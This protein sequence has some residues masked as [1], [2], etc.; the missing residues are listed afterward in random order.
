MFDTCE[1]FRCNFLTYRGETIHSD[2]GHW[3]HE[4]C[5][6]CSSRVC[7]EHCR[8]RD[9]ADCGAARPDFKCERCDN[10]E[11]C[12]ECSHCEARYHHGTA[13]VESTCTRCD[14]CE[15]C[16]DCSH[17]TRCGPVESTCE[18]CDL[19]VGTS[20][21]CCQCFYCRNCDSRSEYGCDRCGRCSDCECDCEPDDDD[22]DGSYSRSGAP[23]RFRS[24]SAP[25]FHTSTKAKLVRNRSRRYAALEIEVSSAESGSELND[26]ADNWDAQIVRDGSLPSGGFEINTAPANGDLLLDQIDD[27]SD[28]LSA[29]SATANSDCGLHVHIDCRD[30]TFYD[31]RRMVLLY[32]QLEPALFAMVPQSRRSANWCVPSGQ[33]YANAVRQ[34]AMP[35]ESK[36]NLIDGI[37][38][39]GTAPR[40]LKAAVSSAKSNKYASERYHALNIH[41]WL[42]RGTIECRLHS[43]TVNGEKLANWALLWVA[44]VDH[45]YRTTEKAIAADTRPAIDILRSIAPSADIAEWIGTRTDKFAGGYR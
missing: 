36:A 45:A 43:G 4:S 22:N 23:V 42:F 10:C 38:N 32:E 8:C 18:H 30:F 19:C 31:M 12:C 28:A 14:H 39:S 44:I 13:A 16:C 25:H 5:G 3:A 41:S 33:K 35:R 11:E 7:E 1:A 34:S 21:D 20:N 2:V 37:Y 27:W 6:Y 9:C 24:N 29:Q 15:Q 26:V 40:S 17:C